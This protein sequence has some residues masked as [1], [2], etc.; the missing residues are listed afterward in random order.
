MSHLS[1]TQT[2]LAEYLEVALKA[3]VVPFIQGIPGS[4]KSAIVKTVAN[5]LNLHLIDL[6][7]SQL[8]VYDLA[9][10]ISPNQQRDKAT[11]LPIDVF[12]LES[13]T[14]PAGKQG[15]LIFLDEFNTADRTTM[16]GAYKL[17]LDRM[18]GN[19]KLHPHTRI[20]CAGNQTTDNAITNNIGTAMQTRLVHITLDLNKK[21]FLE[22]IIKSNWNP[23]LV[24]YLHFNPSMISTFDP[25]KYDEV[26]SFA[27]PRTW[28]F[29]NQQLSKGL[30]NLAEEIQYTVIC[31]SVGEKAGTDFHSYIKF[32]KDI[33]SLQEIL[34]D[35]K[36][37]QLPSDDNIGA[38]WAIVGFLSD[39]YN[40]QTEQA[41]VEYTTRLNENDLIVMAFRLA[42]KRYPNLVRN[43]TV[44]GFIK[45][46]N[47]L[48]NQTNTNP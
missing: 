27:V 3:D 35:P 26:I 15:F 18:I 1:L 10:L 19:H 16:A 47:Q 24:S 48:I 9:G 5:K 4:G 30:L 36:N 40:S 13:D 34:N 33:P 6:R 2:Q 23:M 45:G 29:V 17:V 43:P 21:D 25:G 32:H 42:L 20:I 38:K 8:M 12:P 41:L 22:H 31:G 46:V 44:I 37:C 7:L 11:Y 28:Q 39:K 14:L